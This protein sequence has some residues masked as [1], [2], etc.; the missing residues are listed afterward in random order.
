LPFETATVDAVFTNNMLECLAEPVKCAREIG[1]VL[2]PG[3]T[4]VAAHWDWDSQLFDGSDKATIRRLVHAFADWQQ[5]WMEHS[6]GWMG[7]RL[8]G[9]FAATGCFDGSMH[10]RVLTNTAFE[11]P[12]YGHARAQDMSALARR[13]R[14]NAEEVAEFLDEQAALHAQGRYFYSITGLAYVGMRRL[15][16]GDD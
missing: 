10:A 2:R 6:D 5:S 12:W 7:R 4:V 3:G 8:W 14:V 1:R 13:S 9:T 11:T 16:S 15:T